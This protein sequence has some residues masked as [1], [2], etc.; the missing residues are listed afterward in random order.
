[1]S[2]SSN[3]L[4]DIYGVL[5]GISNDLGR[6]TVMVAEVKDSV[7]KIKET[8]AG[9]IV[10]ITQLTTRVDKL[11]EDLA[12]HQKDISDRVTRNDTRIKAIEDREIE[13]KGYFKVL[14]IVI[15]ILSPILTTIILWVVSNLKHIIILMGFSPTNQ[16][17]D[18]CLN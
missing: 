10:Q 12:T 13:R 4:T 15:A 7:D 16:W 11:Q 17:G 1:M 18:L 14:A 2:P 3:N 8:Q 6:N 5:M 9:Q